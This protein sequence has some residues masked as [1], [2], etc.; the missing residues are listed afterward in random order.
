[1]VIS[2]LVPSPGGV[3]VWMERPFLDGLFGWW[4]KRTK[5]EKD[6]KKKLVI[7]GSNQIQ[8]SELSAVVTILGTD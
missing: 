8:V 1:M 3:V 6:Q 4:S 7:T 2:I 5:S